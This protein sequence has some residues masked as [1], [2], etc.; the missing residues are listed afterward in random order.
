MIKRKVLHENVKP[1][2]VEK[3]ISINTKPKYYWCKFL[4][5]GITFSNTINTND[6]RGVDMKNKK[7][8]YIFILLLFLYFIIGCKGKEEEEKESGSESQKPPNALEQVQQLSDEIVTSTMG[9]DWPGSLDKVR[10]L[11]TK[12]NELYPDLQ[13]KGVGKEEVDAFVSDMNTLMDALISKTLN[14]PQKPPEG[15]VQQNQSKEEE[16]QKQEQGQEGQQEQGQQSQDGEQEQQDQGSEQEQQDQGS[17][18]EQQ[19]Q[20]GEQEQQ[21]Q[22]GEQEQQD[23]G[24]E[25]EQQDQATQE[26]QGDS[27]TEEKDKD[28]KTVLEKMNPIISVAEADLQIINASVEVT[29]HIPEFMDLFKSEVPSELYKLKYLIRH[30]NVFAK[31][32]DWEVVSAGLESVEE[33]WNS[34]KST[35]METDEDMKIKLEQNI[36][37]LK[38]VID[39]KNANLT[40]VKSKLTIENIESV[41]KSIKE[42]EKSK[43]KEKEE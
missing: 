21:D 1:F 20:G 27:D 43:E 4:N 29:K 24:G 2:F 17:E 31:L 11:Q 5:L 32:K 40:G 36:T 10:E 38:D 23:Q 22:G 41:I 3:F 35:V 34:V 9:Q 33:T 7:Y 30:L 42:K 8:I 13:K 28:P 15:Q 14:L 25:Q 6:K 16:P 26:E 12:W 19:D 37:E 39:S 18:Q